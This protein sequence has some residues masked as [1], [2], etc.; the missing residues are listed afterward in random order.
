[1]EKDMAFNLL[2]IM[3][4]ANIFGRFLPNFV[5]DRYVLAQ[6]VHFQKRKC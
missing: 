4:V 1:L 3:N 6:P 2:S 5:A